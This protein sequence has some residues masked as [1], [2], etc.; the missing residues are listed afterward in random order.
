MGKGK[1]KDI[2]DEEPE[3]CSMQGIIAFLLGLVAGT[4]S[5]ITIK[6]CHYTPFT[7]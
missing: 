1:H 7:S 5:T 2:E 4:G 3:G 6:V